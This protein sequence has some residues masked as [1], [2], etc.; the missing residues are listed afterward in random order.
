MFVW[1]NV[2]L[3]GITLDDINVPHPVLPKSLPRDRRKLPRELEPRDPAPGPDGVRPHHARVP[4]VHADLEHAPGPHGPGQEEQRLRLEVGDHVVGVGAPRVHR[5][6]V[7]EQVRGERRRVLLRVGRHP[8]GDGL[9][10]VQGG[11]AFHGEE[12]GKRRDGEKIVSFLCLILKYGLMMMM[13]TYGKP[14]DKVCCPSSRRKNEA[15]PI[16]I[17]VCAPPPYMTL[18]QLQKE[19][20]KRRKKKEKTKSSNVNTT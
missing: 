7:L 11:D 1:F 4:R 18:V 12:G 2:R 9:V 17:H 5:L 13:Q 8:L 6:V 19:E 16:F 20:K 10:W 15:F 14:R 3:E